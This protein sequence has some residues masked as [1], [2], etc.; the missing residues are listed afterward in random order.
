MVD[1]PKCTGDIPFARIGREFRCP[2]CQT[3]LV[4]NY[5]V[6]FPGVLTL[7]LLAEVGAFTFVYSKA[8]GLAPTLALFSVVGGV[9][10]ARA[11]EPERLVRFQ[12]P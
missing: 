2:L 7:A 3:P 1:C 5:P 10:Y 12:R 6:L 8:G 11:P 4:S 9:V